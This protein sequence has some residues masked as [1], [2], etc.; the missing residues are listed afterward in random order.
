MGSNK[1]LQAVCWGTVGFGGVLLLAPGLARQG[2]SLLIFSDP[3]VIDLWPEPARR[4]VT[5]LHGVLGA[6]MVGWAVALLLAL[7][8]EPGTAPR[9]WWLVAV[10]VACWYVP[11]TVFS[12]AVGAWQNAVLNSVFAAAF[13]AGLALARG[14]AQFK[15]A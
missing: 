4:Y 15:V 3:G 6:V 7:R 14:R 5:L 11:D 10:S 13:A 8:S 9:G 2:F 12:L 1:L